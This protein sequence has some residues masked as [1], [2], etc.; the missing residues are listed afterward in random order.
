[1]TLSQLSRHKWTPPLTR[2]LLCLMNAGCHGK[3]RLYLDFRYQSSCSTECAALWPLTQLNLTSIRYCRPVTKMWRETF[4]HIP[5]YERARNHRRGQT[6]SG[7]LCWPH[8]ELNLLQPF[9]FYLL[10]VAPGLLPLC[11][12]IA[13][14]IPMESDF[15]PNRSKARHVGRDVRCDRI[16]DKFR[17][18]SHVLGPGCEVSFFSGTGVG[19]LIDHHDIVDASGGCWI[20]TW[21][22]LYYLIIQRPNLLRL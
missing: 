10:F 9:T 22:C 3:L 7:I 8:G 19:V 12:I 13:H 14:L 17:T 2:V 15:G 20:Q 6:E 16:Y 18:F 1:M 11:F 5:A 4:I 21:V